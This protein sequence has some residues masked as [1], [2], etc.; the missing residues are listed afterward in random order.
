MN[1]EGFM[2]R[3]C[4]CEREILK[5]YNYTVLLKWRAKSVHDVDH[6]ENDVA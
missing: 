6:I 4:K 5:W 3:M 1:S 2:A